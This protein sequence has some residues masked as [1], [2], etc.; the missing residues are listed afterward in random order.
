MMRSIVLSVVLY[1]T[2]PFMLSNPTTT[3]SRLKSATMETVEAPMKPQGVDDIDG[4][5]TKIMGEVNAEEALPAEMQPMISKFMETYMSVV[6]GLGREPSSALPVLKQYVELVEDQLKTPYQ[7]QPYHK[8]VYAP[9][10]HYEMDTAFMEPLIDLEDSRLIGAENIATINEQLAAGDNVVF[11]SNHQTEADPSAWSAIF[12]RGEGMGTEF[13]V[14]NMIMVA[15]DRVTSDPVAVPFSK[16]RNLLCIYSKRHIENPP[17]KKRMKQMHNTKTMGAMLKLL[18][19]GGSCIWVAPSGGRDRPNDDDIFD[20]P[21]KF[22]EKS[23]EMFRL[24]AS[25]VGLFKKT[26]FW[27]MAML[28]HRLFPPPAKVQSTLGEPRIAMR[29]SVNICIRPE[30]DFDAVT[31]PGC[32]A[33]NFPPNCTDDREAARVLAAEFAYN[34]C[35]AAY[36]ALLDDASHRG[37]P[38]YP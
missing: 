28:T 27:P 32:I 11:L 13:P 35:N 29:G 2:Q 16:A 6:L 19:E 23:V 9:V 24:M 33:D 26:H 12:D 14:K 1:H 4:L 5:V 20:R 25:K 36:Q 8:A 17:E 34:E 15:G 31:A 3:R 10:D 18:A 30:I 22:D 7:F 21:A 38:Y 37:S